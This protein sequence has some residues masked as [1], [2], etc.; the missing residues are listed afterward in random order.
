MNDSG[1]RSTLQRNLL[2][3]SEKQ[4]LSTALTDHIEHYFADIDA[5]NFLEAN[6]E[7]LHG[8]AVQHHRLAQTRA[9]GQAVISLYTPDFDR[10]GWHSPHTVIDIVTDDM[11]FLVDSVTMLIHDHGLAI[12]RLIHPILGIERGDDG[13]IRRSAQRGAPGTHSE[14]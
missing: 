14:S 6:L 8:A 1:N 12:H 11:P 2:E 9:A 13:Q 10:H 3:I 7:E 5:D 4:K